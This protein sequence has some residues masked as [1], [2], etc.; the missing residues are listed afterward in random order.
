MKPIILDG[1]KLAKEIEEELKL[2]VKKL[3]EK[4]GIVQSL[5]IILIGENPASEI[6]VKLKLS[7]CERIGVKTKLIRLAEEATTEDIIKTIEN[8]NKDSE[9]NGILFQH[10]APKQIDEEKCFR[11]IVSGKDVDGLNPLSDFR[12][13]TPLGIITLLKYYNIKIE[14]KEAVVVGRSR[15]LGKPMAMMLLDENATVT[16]CHSKT[17][18]LDKII[19]RADILVAAIGKPK[20]IQGEWIKKGAVIVDAGFNKGGIG[21]IDLEKAIKKCSAYTPVPGGVGPMTIISL[22]SRVVEAAEK[23][24]KN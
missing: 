22:I 11:T 21:D 19:K 7:A 24:N 5:A 16:I 14:G 12:A 9:I 13:A 6:Y 20:F 2:R 4:T 3:K 15:I 8:C 23:Q 10:P 18:N 1:K 17:K